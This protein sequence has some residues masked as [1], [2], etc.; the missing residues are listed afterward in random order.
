MD[1]Q[2]T[3]SPRIFW[4]RCGC[5]SI[6]LGM[7]FFAALALALAPVSAPQASQRIEP[8]TF[9][10]ELSEPE[11]E[12][13][14]PLPPTRTDVPY[15][16]APAPRPR[17][18][19]RPVAQSIA[20]PALPSIDSPLVD[21]DPEPDREPRP[22][23]I[24]LDPALHAARLVLHTD[25]PIAPGPP[26]SLRDDSP[27]RRPTPIAEAIAIVEGS[28]YE[29]ANARGPFSEREYRVAQR[30]DGAYHYDGIGFEGIILPDGSIRFSDRPDLSFDASTMTVSFDIMDA[31]MRLTGQDPYMSERIGFVEATE[32]LRERLED[33]ARA[34]WSAAT[35]QHLRGAVALI[36]QD[37][38]RSPAA[39]RR[40][41][42]EL[43]DEQADGG[44]GAPARDI[45]MAFI[46]EERPLGTG[47]VFG[48]LELARLNRARRSVEL[49]D[50]DGP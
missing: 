10:I 19:R 21:R 38:R 30:P 46:A 23:T 35:L 16:P 12:P 8:A 43:W 27:D 49:F 4:S 34:A 36:W 50:P 32:E 2:L 11:P 15:R 17:T 31:I 1:F 41:L 14:V 45:V 44:E 13:V 9:T 39:R 18:P 48:E 28:L 6:S 25:G 7:H 3:V 22:P 37:E 47:M 20:P 24:S 29:D 40:A 5:E 42:F 33:E 26:A